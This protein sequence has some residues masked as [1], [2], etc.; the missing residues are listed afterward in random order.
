MFVLGIDAGG[1]TTR[2]VL[3]TLDGQVLAWTS[4]G[5]ANQNSSGGNLADTLFTVLSTVDGGVVGDVVGDVV[6]GVVAAAGSA[7]PAA[8]SRAQ[9]AAQSFPPITIGETPSPPRAATGCCGGF[10]GSAGGKASTQT[11]PPLQRPGNSLSK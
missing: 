4:T 6:G 2:C 1:T 3:A 5:G 11:C 9:A 7:A 8:R 10:F